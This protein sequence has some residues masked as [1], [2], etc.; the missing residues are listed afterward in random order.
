MKCR[1]SGQ[2]S[3]SA[4]HSQ[5]S[6]SPHSLPTTHW[7][8]TLE[9]KLPVWSVH[10]KWVTSLPFQNQLFCCV[11][12][13]MQTMPTTLNLTEMEEVGSLPVPQL[14][15]LWPNPS[16]TLDW[17]GAAPCWKMAPDWLEGSSHF[18]CD[19]ISASKRPRTESAAIRNKETFPTD[20]L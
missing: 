18:C 16:P 20:G 1:D 12:F 15:H 3:W 11:R 19:H 10:I 6:I 8:C 14:G 4:T 2:S 9:N 5:L 13:L 7:L 17:T